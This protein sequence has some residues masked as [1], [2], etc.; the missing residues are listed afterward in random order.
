MRFHQG[1]IEVIGSERV[2]PAEEKEVS[3]AGMAIQQNAT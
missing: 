3:F 2:D 1:N